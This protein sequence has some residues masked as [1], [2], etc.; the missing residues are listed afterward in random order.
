MF[1]L[2]KKQLY[3]VQE[4]LRKNRSCQSYRW[5][6][7]LLCEDKQPLIEILNA[8]S[9]PRDWRVIPLGDSADGGERDGSNTD[10]CSAENSAASSA[11]Q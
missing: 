11:K 6:Q 10:Q 2:E 8:Q 9:S 1:A 3:I 5:K 7:V 4:P